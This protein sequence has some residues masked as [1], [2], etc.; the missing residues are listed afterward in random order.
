[1]HGTW[2]LVRRMFVTLAAVA[3][4]AA[5]SAG[6]EVW[7]STSVIEGQVTN[8]DPGAAVAPTVVVHGYDDSGIDLTVALEGIWIADRKTKGGAFIEIAWP[9]AA[10]YGQFGAPALPVVRNLFVVPAGAEVGIDVTAP[11]PC[12]VDLVDA[13]FAAQVIPVQAPIEK[14]PGARDRAPFDFDP[15]AYLVDSF[16][17]E[18]RVEVTKLGVVAGNQLY[19]LEVRPLAYNPARGELLLW[20]EID[21]SL[22]FKGGRAAD[23][24]ALPNLCGELLNPPANAKPRGQNYLIVVAQAYAGAIS[25]FVVGKE[26]QG[27]DVMTYEVAPGTSNTTIRNYI[28]S[29]WGTADQPDYILLVG[30]T[31]TIPCWAGQGSYS[32]DTDIY[33]A[34]MDGGDDW[35]PDIPLGRFSVRSTG[36]LQAVIDKTLFIEAGT[37]PD[38]EYVLRAVFMASN[39]NYTVS[40]GTHNYVISNYMDPN[41]FTSD[42][43]YCHTY[44]AT[45]QQVRNAFNNGRIYG[46]YS[47]H[48]SSTSWADGP[49][50]SQSDVENLTNEG[51]YPFVC[52]FACLTGD[53]KDYTEC[54]TETWLRVAEKGAAAMYGA[55]VSSYWDEDDKLE[56]FL[57]DVIYLDDIR[58]VSPAWQAAFLLYLDHFGA[59]DF[60]RMYFEMY[61]LMGDPSLYIP[62]PGGGADMQVSPAGSF[63][64]EGPNGGPFTPESKTYT[65]KNNAEYP[66][67]YSVNKAATWIDLD[68]TGGTIPAGGTADVVVSINSSA[69]YL[70]NGYYEDVID[71]VNETNHDGDTSRLVSLEVGVPVP[72]ILFDLNTNPGWS[73]ESNWGFGQP[74]GGGGEYGNPDP[75]GGHTGSNV[76]G[77]NLNGDY[78]NN[79]QERH[80]T[81]TAINCSDLT[82]V[83]L[84]F[85]RWL[86]V[87]TSSYDHAYV[88]VS[89]NGS[90]WTTVWE[91]DDYI[92]E[93][94]WSQ[95]AYDISSIAD[96]QPTVYIRWTM[97]T[98]DGSWRYCGWNIDDIEIWGVE[99]SAPCPWDVNDTGVVNIDDLFEVL[100]HWGENG[101]ICD[102]NNDGIVN[103]DDI[104]AIL[105]N[106]GPCP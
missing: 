78:E 41:G 55:S 69:N 85:W 15:A 103:I 87:E 66:I 39:D 61:N 84:K 105:A 22:N 34:C 29:L 47:G 52:S 70:P 35:Y 43:L 13:G 104:F 67:D 95:Q 89:T 48:G 31:D 83:Q 74:T 82:Q 3:L 93:N 88:R 50:F 45:T 91:N 63:A 101:G 19:L 28:L 80:L 94:S 75:T 2:K 106:W 44:N 7:L 16:T 8:A 56:R 72:V 79:M 98:T 24:A 49:P 23:A 92:E 42:K 32:P 51:L 4:F 10:F 26:G 25:P 33:Y 37:Y 59:T 68:N 90:S 27:Y 36:E 17:P 21:V 58:E 96:N 57:F 18:G 76:Y 30:D 5:P 62:L 54:F 11:R 77:Y 64:S 86:G 12:R 102:V 73:M 14:L 20:P 9:E 38:Q 81:T 1:M 53:F 65:V 6:G 60:T 97:G 40:E 46:I 100:G 71:F 99:P